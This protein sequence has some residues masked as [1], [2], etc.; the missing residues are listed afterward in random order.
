MARAA[1]AALCAGFCWVAC[2]ARADVLA[3]KAQAFRDALVARHVAPEGFVIYEVDLRQPVTAGQQGA[4]ADTPT[5]TGL[6]A[7]ASCDRAELESGAAREQALDDARR[8]LDGL[9]FLMDVTGRPGLLAR[10]VQLGPPPQER[11][12]RRWFAGAAGFEAYAWRG[13]ASHDQYANGLLPALA[14]CRSLLPEPSRALARA[15]AE[16]LLADSLQLVD[17][18][19]R[20]TRYGDLSPRAGYGFNSIAKLT[21]YGA[22]ALAAELDP[23]PRWAQQR[24]RLR[25]RERVVDRSQRTNVR[26]LGITNFSNDLMAW[27]L[28]RVLI[29]LA[30]RSGDPALAALERGMRR[31]W[32]RVAQDRN[33]YF[34]ALWC[35]LARA[36]CGAELLEQVRDMLARFPLEK[37]RL[38]PAPEL[39][40]LPRAWIPGRKWRRHARD[41]VPIELRP[42][43]SLEWKSSPYRI[44]AAALP[45]LE[46]TGID[47][48]L[49]YWTYRGIES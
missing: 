7:A 47:Y 28:Y 34:T 30:R 39:A 20:R 38:A 12:E 10:G 35:Q 2:A 25:D 21:G 33:A 3:E 9:A 23:D 32:K 48:L 18:D 14:A 27:N 6:W 49:A 41:P 11:D 22:F 29:P 46:Y 43:S 1:R 31:A 19:G 15:F 37:R 44:S 40:E 17:P 45:H 42:A 26:I 16:R 5:F 24:D 8:A 4:L 13:N 36:E